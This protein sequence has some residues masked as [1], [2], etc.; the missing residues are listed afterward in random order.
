MFLVDLLIASNDM[1]D[2]EDMRCN[3]CPPDLL[4]SVSVACRVKTA[5][6]RPIHKHIINQVAHVHP[7]LW[8]GS[9]GT[10][11]SKL[12]TVSQSVQPFFAQLAAESPSPYILQWAAPS[13]SPSKLPLR[14]GGYGPHLLYGVAWVHLNPHP[15][16]L[17]DRFRRFAGLTILSV[18]HDRSTDR[19]IDHASQS[20]AIGRIYV[21]LR[22][23][24]IK[25]TFVHFLCITWTFQRI[26]FST[27]YWQQR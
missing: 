16:R 19:P 13:P 7:H 6:K 18:C 23:G 14:M 20:V 17:L 15:N 3:D 1:W 11:E 24:L 27:L 5:D 8:H 9:L 22:C 4:I 2:G 25:I 26:K 12:Q 21:V 10:P